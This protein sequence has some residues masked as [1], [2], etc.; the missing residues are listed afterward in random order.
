MCFKK[1]I[2]SINQSQEGIRLTIQKVE[3]NKLFL[4]FE[5]S[6]NNISMEY[7]VD[8]N[9]DTLF[10]TDILPSEHALQTIQLSTVGQTRDDN[11]MG[12][13]VTYKIE[14]KKKEEAT[15]LKT[16]T[17]SH[18]RQNDSTKLKINLLIINSK[19]M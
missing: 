13:S 8:D 18:F 9:W 19:L 16:I 10:E 17:F 2:Y 11:M 14:K 12:L 5:K 7:F 6:E 4:L 3:N 15:I 1:K